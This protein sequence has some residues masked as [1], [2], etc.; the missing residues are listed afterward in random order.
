VR[1]PE[2][3]SRHEAGEAGAALSRDGLLGGR[4]TL[5]QPRQGLR[6]AIDAP[7]LAAAVAAPPA[8]C[9][10]ELGCG[11][12]AA[13]LCLLERLARA[14]PAGV[15]V[16]GL[17]L[18]PELAELARRNAA[19]NGRGSSF[20]VITGDLAAP[21]LM[22]APHAFDGVFM[23]P[24]YQ[25]AEAG[26]ASPQPTRALAAS[27]GALGLADWL[28]AALRLLKPKGRLTLIHRAD[29]LPELLRALEGRIGAI[30]VLPLFPGDGRAAKR[31]LLTGI[32]D[33]RAPFTLLPGLT[34]HDAEGAF[35]P[36]AEAILR[37]GGALK[38]E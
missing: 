19:E 31:I 13:S 28:A 25:R 18:Q 30:A 1:D 14:G 35:T 12:G 37:E 20:R 5:L 27:E 15:T 38:L 22:L 23:N 4:V 2:S 33:S 21:P 24:P 26:R 9:L 36:E 3:E 11:V 6:A 7:L 17:E 34:L 32:K 16:T 10:A 8:G 29:R